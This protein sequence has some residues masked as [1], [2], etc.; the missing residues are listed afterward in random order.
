MRWWFKDEQCKLCNRTFRAKLVTW[1]EL[2]LLID[3]QVALEALC[4]SC[5][6]E[7]G[8][9]EQDE[10]EALAHAEWVANVEA[11]NREEADRGK[12]YGYD[13]DTLNAL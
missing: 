11:W 7:W 9:E 13:D 5:A 1:V 4:P 6:K 10:Y 8:R 3:G 2:G 12:A